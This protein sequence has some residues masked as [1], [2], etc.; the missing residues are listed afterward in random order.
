MSKNQV[1]KYLCFRHS[2]WIKA[3]SK[4]IFTKKWDIFL[5]LPFLEKNNE[6]TFLTNIK[7][8]LDK[9]YDSSGIK[10][11]S[12]ND[13]QY[14]DISSTEHDFK[15][16]YHP[17]GFTQFSWTG[18]ILSG[19]NHDWSAKAFWHTS[20]SLDDMCLWP[21]IW[22]SLNGNLWLIKD[23]SMDKEY[24][25]IPLYKRWI[26][27]DYVSH[28]DSEQNM[29]LELFIRKMEEDDP[30][31]IWILQKDPS[32][33]NEIIWAFPHPDEG[34]FY[35]R[36]FPFVYNNIVYLLWVRV[37]IW[38]WD[39]QDIEEKFKQ[40]R[41]SMWPSMG[42]SDNPDLWYNLSCFHGNYWYDI[43]QEKITKS[44]DLP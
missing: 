13:I 2:K 43:F 8:P 21:F 44:I 16:S 19:K 7:F 31:K 33:D 42:K 27:N 24:S 28:I 22:I 23:H 3:I 39:R 14:I 11:L 30:R 37:L 25:L 36:T 29:T 18:K 15:L 35:T 6:P 26:T 20:F 1:E 12:E 4:I 32:L 40:I 10:H 34:I 38:E 5:S 9:I 17:D 41:Y